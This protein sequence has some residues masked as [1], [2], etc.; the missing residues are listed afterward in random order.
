MQQWKN[1]ENRSVIGQ[2]IDKTLWL[3]LLGH[4]V[5]A[6]RQK[7]VELT[8][9]WKDKNVTSALKIRVSDEVDGLGSVLVWCG[10]IDIK[11][12]G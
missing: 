8:T 2:D 10:G 4:P 7:A 11:E 12:I 3:T 9:I 5:Y 6:I 1:F